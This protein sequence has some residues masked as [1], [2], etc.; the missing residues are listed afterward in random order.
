MHRPALPPLQAWAAPAGWQ[1]I[2]F[3]A[4]L[5]LSPR[6]PRTFDAW[7]AHMRHG[8]ADALVLLGDLFEVWVGDDQ[9][10]RSFEQ[11]CVEV[12]AEAARRR[13]VA[14]MPGNRDFLVGAAMHAACA[15]Q[16]LP[17]PSLLD[18]WGRRVLLSHGDLL[19]LADTEYQ[20][21]RSLSRGERWQREFLAQP[22]AQR[23]D[24]A[25]LARA[26]SEAKKQATGVDPELWAD[27]DRDA[28]LAWLRACAA[29]DLV[30]GHTHRPGSEAL[31]PNHWR[32]VL[33]DW[34]LDHGGPPRAGV[35]RLRREGFV[36]LAP[37]AR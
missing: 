15:W 4:D 31:G 20:Q 5:H 9:G 25:L 33:T 10:Q 18:A 6:T 13:F 28:A 17:D 3:I 8:P 34:D 12:L 27:V 30:H 37:T 16:V 32:H 19:C 26:E 35:L 24:Q 1:A 7:A 22:L 14:F 23:L 36:R 29:T 21:F 2:D 11:G